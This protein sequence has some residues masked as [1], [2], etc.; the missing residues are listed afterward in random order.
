[1]K[2]MD[3]SFQCCIEDGSRSAAYVIQLRCANHLKVLCS[4]GIVLNVQAKG[5]VRHYQVRVKKLNANEPLRKCRKEKLVGKTVGFIRQTGQTVT[6]NC[7]PV[8]DQ[9]ALRRQEL[10]TGFYTKR[11]K[12]LLRCADT[13]YTMM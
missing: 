9:P 8:T 11:E 1:M 2:R 10:Y 6:V 3:S 4:K 7:L 5:S 13:P 12:L